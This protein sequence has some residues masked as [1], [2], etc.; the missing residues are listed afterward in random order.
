MASA[1]RRNNEP[2]IRM[3]ASGD[4]G[5]WRGVAGVMGADS[6]ASGARHDKWA[7]ESQSHGRPKSELFVLPPFVKRG[8]V[9]PSPSGERGT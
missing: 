3:T 7:P 9:P 2:Q 6:S 5:S 1:S 4:T 8:P